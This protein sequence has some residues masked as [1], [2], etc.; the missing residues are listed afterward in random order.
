[1]GPWPRHALRD[2]FMF[3][4]G[5]RKNRTRIEP[6]LDWGGSRAASDDLRADPADRPVKTR[7]AAAKASAPSRSPKGRTRSSRKR[8]RGVLRRLAYWTFVLGVWAVIGVGA[9]VAYYASQL[10]ADRQARGAE[11]PAQYRDSR[12]GRIASRQSRRH[13]RPGR[14]A[15]RPASL[16]AQSLHR[17]RGPALLLPYGASI[18]SASAARSFATSPAAGRWRAARRSPSNSPRTCS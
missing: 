1:M 10:P 15:D 4:R 18:R 11:T 12:I 17:D 8:R 6:R 16:S 7:A 9:V 5:G 3:G 14:P 2:S 13:R